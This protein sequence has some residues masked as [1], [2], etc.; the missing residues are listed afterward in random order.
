MLIFLFNEDD[1]III[2]YLKFILITYFMK[3]NQ[4]FYL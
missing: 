2:I 4:I 3:E 1:I